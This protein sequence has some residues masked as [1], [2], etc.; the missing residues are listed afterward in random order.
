M[1]DVKEYEAMAKFNLPDTERL[2]ISGRIEELTGSF[3]AIEK[4]NTDNIEPLVSV[5]DTKNILR[6]DIAKKFITRED[7]LSAAPEQYDGYFQVPKTLD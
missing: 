6:N 4:I 3:S 1:K 7:L 5:L 2:S